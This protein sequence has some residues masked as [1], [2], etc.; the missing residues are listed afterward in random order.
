M[1]NQNSDLAELDCISIKV[2]QRSVYYRN[3]SQSP[4]CLLVT[5]L[6]EPA[7]RRGMK[8]RTVHSSLSL[9]SHTVYGTF[10]LILKSS[11][12][13]LIDLIVLPHC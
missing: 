9:L 13:H 2:A 12:K 4:S 7:K 6:P 1:E 5:V 11:V 8:V 10:T 3:M